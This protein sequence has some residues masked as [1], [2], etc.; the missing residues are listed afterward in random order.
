MNRVALLIGLVGI[1]ASSPAW[2]QDSDDVDQIQHHFETGVALYFDQKYDEAIDEFQKGH[3]LYPDPIFLYNISMAHG[4]MGRMDQSLAIAELAES[5]GLGEPDSTQNRARM[6]A[7]RQYRGAAEIANRSAIE[8]MQA[9][10]E[11][12][13][14]SWLS[15]RDWRFWTGVGAAGVGVTSI[16]IG[17][18][19][20]AS[21]N[22]T[23]LAYEKAAQAEDI[24]TYNR[25]RKT[26]ESDQN[27]AITFYV[28]GGLLV[29]GGSGMIAWSLTDEK[30]LVV[31]PTPNG[32]AAAYSW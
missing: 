10:P 2:A 3:A 13:S 22:D 15:Q 12:T 17:G 11:P 29:A 1:L 4:K 7:L 9:T 25:L 14:E 28:V 6:A 5:G 30:N 24:A 18:I 8:R 31:L 27:K 23:I 19:V 16:I 21:L 32:A 26:I 20:D